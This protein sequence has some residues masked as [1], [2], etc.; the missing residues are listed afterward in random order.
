[1]IKLEMRRAS[2]AIFD[3]NFYL[4]LSAVSGAEGVGEESGEFEL[5][6]GEGADGG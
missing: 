3:L 2:R 6:E 4:K 5:V 1:M